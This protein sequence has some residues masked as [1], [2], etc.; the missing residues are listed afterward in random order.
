MFARLVQ[1]TI[2]PARARELAD[3]FARRVI[4]AL[5]ETDGCMYCGLAQD[6]TDPRR[7]VSLTF[8]ASQRHAE[9]YE[10]SGLF[11][12]LFEESHPYLADT[13]ELTVRL[14]EDLRLE[15][16]PAGPVATVEGFREVAPPESTIIRPSSLDSR[17]LRLATILA[18]PGK[19]E[20][21]AGLFHQEVMPVLRTTPGCRYVQLARSVH[22]PSRFVAITVWTSREAAAECETRGIFDRITGMLRP[23]LS[24]LYQWKLDLHP[25]E[26]SRTATSDDVRVRSFTLLTGRASDHL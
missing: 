4:P 18:E 10:Q 17:H 12:T 24:G 3:L 6:A 11:R 21:L 23:T 19:E 13:S 26:A 14:S 16:T 2:D 15:S 7:A 8:W 5:L 20:Q 22:E 9:A 25:G 1:I